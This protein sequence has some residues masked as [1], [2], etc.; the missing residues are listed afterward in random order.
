MT[1]EEKLQQIENNTRKANEPG[2]LGAGCGLI[3]LVWLI[4]AAI[5]V[6]F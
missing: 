4:I 1:I 2:C 3:I 5:A 6:I